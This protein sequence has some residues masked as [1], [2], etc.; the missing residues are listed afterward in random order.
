MSRAVMIDGKIHGAPRCGI[1][2]HN[3]NECHTSRYEPSSAETHNRGPGLR[4]L[5]YSPKHEMSPC[6]GR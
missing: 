4:P 5:G 3:C 2:K 1:A 6:V